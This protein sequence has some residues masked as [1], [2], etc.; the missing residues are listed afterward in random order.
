MKKFKV[1]Y[2]ERQSVTREIE[3]ETDA[4]ARKKMQELITNGELDISY[5]DLD[6]SGVYAE[7]VKEAK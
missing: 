6:D 7:E 2:W 1:T 4:E 3:A 5:A